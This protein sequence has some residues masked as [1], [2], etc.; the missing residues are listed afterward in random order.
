MR[1]LSLSVLFLLFVCFN[2]SLLAQSAAVSGQ[3]YDN[4]GATLVGAT[5]ELTNI[6]TKV[7]LTTTNNTDGSFI[8]PPVAPGHYEISIFAKGFRPWQVTGITLEIGQKKFVAV[9]MEL[10]SVSQ[11]VT[12][13]DAPPELQTEN[14]DRSTLL[15]PSFVSNLPLDPRNPLILILATVG[16]TPNNGGT[17]GTNNTTQSTT[18]QFR[19]NGAKYATTD[20]LID[21]GANMV[22]YNSQAAGIP[23][24]DATSEFRVM[25]TAYAP[26]YGYTSGGI[27]NMSLKSG[28]NTMH[29]G[30]WEY[31]RN[32]T[33][34]ANGYNANNAGIA[35]P[36]LL[37]NQFGFQLGGPIDIPKFY[38]GHG[39]TFFYFSYEG[40]RNTAEQVTGGYSALVPTDAMAGRNGLPGGDFSV[41]SNSANY[42]ITGI[43]VY[44]PTNL[45]GTGGTRVQFA[46]NIISANRL[47]PVGKKLM[48]LFPSPTPGYF[49][50]SNG[51]ANFYSN[52][53]E[54]DTNNSID[55]RVDHQ[56]NAKHSIFG[57]FDRF[58]NYI[59]NPDY[60]GN[61]QE[62][63]NSDDRIPG[64]HALVSH[65][66]S[67]K[68]DVIFTH[69]GSWGHSESNRAS[70]QPLSPS[71]VFGFN[72][73][74]A[75]GIANTFTPQILAVTGQLGAIGNAEPLETNKS[76]VYQYQADISWIDG[77]HTFKVGTDIRRYFVQHWDPQDLTLTG[78]KALTG[79]ASPSASATN[80]SAIAEIMLGFTPVVSGFQPRVTLRD[81][82]YFGYGEDT[83]KIT[84]KLTA[85]YGLRYGI[86]GSWVTDGN[87][88][89]YLDTSSPSPI[90]AAAGLPNLVGGIG[91]PGVSISSRTEQTPSLFHIEPRMG[92]SYALN[93]NTVFHAGFG[94]FRY[95]QASEASYSELGGSARVSTSVSSQTV[96]TA[97]Q[98]VPGPST[99]S[100]GYYTLGNPFY[101]GGGAPPAPYGNNPSPLAG[102]NVGSGP[103]SINLGQTV[104]GD[105][106]TQTGPYQQIASL[107]MQRSLPNHFVAT[108]GVINSEGVRMRSGMQLNQLSNTVLSSKCLPSDATGKTCTALSTS[109]ANNNP[110]YKVIT[111]SSS[112]LSASSVPAGNLLRAYP[113][114]NKFNAIDVG[115]GHSTYRALQVTL[116][117]R[118]ANGLSVLVGYTFS[119]GID[120]TGDSSSTFSIQNN[121]CHTCERSI[122]EQDATHVFTENAVYELPIGHK[123]M[124]L[125][126]GAVGIIA[127]G[128][129]IGNAYRFTTGQPVQLTQT[130]T[131][132]VGN[133]VLR[134][135]I[136]SGVSLAPTT[137]T[138]AFNPAAFV[139]TPAYMFGNAAR[140]QS[141][142]RYPNFQKL[143]VFIQK[144]T[145]FMDDRM[146]FTVRF[147]ALNAP[148][149]V[150]FGPPA[151]NISSLATFGNK[152]TTQTNDPR[153]CQL[154][155]R[156]T[157]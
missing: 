52:A 42:P 125:N 73:A 15:E 24:V 133:A 35:R 65:T 20:L 144:Q 147:E 50:A 94:I 58:S 108:I 131:S 91:I 87:L 70:K 88:L 28:V 10:G 8:L 104:T 142:I 7:K 29:G 116:Q 34:D 155:G 25:T 31:F 103:L 134:P 5:I 61:D 82:V 150:V 69:H 157:F 4:Q 137:S 132:L 120:Q 114:F 27:V 38:D 71:G 40:L 93:D 9:V 36:P 107:D 146:S 110:F 12:V 16:V 154:S 17:S 111:D 1:S 145:K 51:A 54:Y 47:D 151:A 105:L 117:H 18:N 127:G 76:S 45:T 129:Q 118:E 37:R 149:S 26:E 113:Q 112:F 115:W 126:S 56:F 136:V 124:W 106:R 75:P 19:I 153:E 22:A 139:A 23:G 63:T 96:G 72:A 85:T 6:D 152:S 148:N 11:A 43:S 95:P 138:Q 39:K 32:E 98:I 14:A 3:I 79:G 30:A 84:R 135:T 57:H 78:G 74:A 101:A 100:P 83:Y 97:V 48:Q 121:G 86:I 64:Y 128:W 49:A 140:W 55:L 44:D 90:A 109:V 89:D 41:A 81:M 68:N 2:G 119:K 143:D 141:K 33:M 59:F 46:N 66:W 62:P 13:S 80:G 99:T 77:K 102:N 122:S 130:A 21:G 67:L 156:F 92:L 53:T 123:K 60:Y